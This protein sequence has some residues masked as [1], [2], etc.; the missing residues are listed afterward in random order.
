MGDNN[1]K[2]SRTMELMMAMMGA[3]YDKD[4][5]IRCM[6]C[7]CANEC[8]Q[9]IDDD[10]PTFIDPDIVDKIELRHL[11]EEIMDDAMAEI[12]QEA[13]GEQAQGL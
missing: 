1:Q 11:G 8:C 4:G 13:E 3:Y 7:H 2:P 6:K 12:S 9:C 5:D 10:S